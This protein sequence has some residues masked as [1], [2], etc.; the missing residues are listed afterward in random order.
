M[1]TNN[2]NTQLANL[3]IVFFFWGFLAASNGIFIPF[4]KS[5]F[6]LSQFQSQLVDSAFYGAYFI[7]SLILFL[8]SEF[9]GI[10]LLNRIGY[11]KGIIYGLLISV[12]GAA[13]MIPAVNM[14]SFAAIL[15]A[16][17]IIALGF[18]LQQTAAQPFVLALGAPETGS[19][20]L[21]LTGSVNSIGTTVGPILV[22]LLLFGTFKN[23][24]V[25]SA[26]KNADVGS[27]NILYIILMVVFGGIAAFL[28]FSKMPSVT[29][30][31]STKKAG[32]ATRVILAFTAILAICIVLGLTTQINALVLLLVVLFSLIGLLLYSLNSAQQARAN[33][34]AMIENIGTKNTQRDAA[35]AESEGW[36][37]MQYTQLVLGMLGIFT[38]VGVEVSVQSNMGALLQLPEYGSISD[39]ELGPYISMYWGSL[40]VGRWT[41]SIGAFNFSKQMR[42]LLTVIV[43]LLAFGFVLGANAF[44]GT[45]VSNLYPY[46]ICV[47]IQI[48]GFFYG[49]EK[50]ARTLMTF[51]IMAVVAMLIGLF[52]TG[53]ISLYA[54]L[55]GGLFCSIMW[56]CIFSLA[57]AG[58]GNYTSQGSSFLIMMILGGGVIPPIQGK[59][60]DMAGIGIHNSYWITVVCFA[61]L[62]FYGYYS[63]QVL[64][65]Q[66]IDFDKAIEGGH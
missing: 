60:A 10:D 13:L 2:N 38:Y 39:A 57:V 47:F 43:P 32:K 40:M 49:Q 19:H 65:K 15:G 4:C 21:N 12:L 26:V 16:L 56:P 51:G 48:A 6:Q 28:W 14:G 24:E 31:D 45:D 37:A 34:D 11:K 46:I 8:S 52:T 64:Q 55:S 22:S 50:P 61:Y 53:T 23:S 33:L 17:F 36:G 35:V 18:S 54:F 3:T 58:L 59:L 30:E 1:N 7:G 41:G 5:H 29:G 66:G 62:A 20:R 27:I 9:M 25:E 42:N 44:R 63:R